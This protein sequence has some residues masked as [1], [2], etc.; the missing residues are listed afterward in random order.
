VQDTS[1]LLPFVDKYFANAVA[2][3]KRHTF[4]IAEYLMV[5]LYPINLANEAL[6][7][8]TREAIHDANIKEIPALRRILIE[9]LAA[10]DRALV[11]QQ[12]D[13]KG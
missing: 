11:A 1:L 2:I 9:N 8:K 13:L 7:A 5:N 12:R 4:K 10:V 3:W 6:A